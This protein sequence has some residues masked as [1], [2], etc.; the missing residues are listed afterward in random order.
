MMTLYT[1]IC[2]KGSQP[3]DRDYWKDTNHGGFFTNP[4]ITGIIMRKQGLLAR[5]NTFSFQ[6]NSGSMRSQFWLYFG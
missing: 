3:T 4:H 2:I 1:C 5:K 6:T